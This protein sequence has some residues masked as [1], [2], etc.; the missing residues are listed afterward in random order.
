MNISVWDTLLSTIWLGDNK[1]R[2]LKDLIIF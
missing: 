1:N 2:E